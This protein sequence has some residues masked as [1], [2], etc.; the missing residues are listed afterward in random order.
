MYTDNYDT[1]LRTTPRGSVFL[2]GLLCGAAVGAAIGLLMAPSSG[3]DFRGH[4]SDS[5]ERIRRKAGRGYDR[6]AS[7]VDDLV[8]RGKRAVRRGRDT[9]NE[10]RQNAADAMDDMADMADE[11]V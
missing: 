2:T 10:V 11:S 9:F 7:T 1:D 4:L 5:A 8:G 6:A 3:A